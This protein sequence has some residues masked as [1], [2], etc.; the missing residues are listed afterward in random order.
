MKGPRNPFYIR[1]AEQI[2]SDR[3][4]LR[5]FSPGILDILPDTLWDRI[6]VF[7]SAPGGGKTSLLQIFTANALLSLYSYKDFDQYKDIYARMKEVGAI[8]DKGP[9]VLGAMLSCAHTYA[10]LEDLTVNDSQ[11]ERLLLSLLNVRIVL[12]ILRS[13][14]TLK[15]YNYPEDLEKITLECQQE[16]YLPPGVPHKG[17]G[18]IYFNWA[19]QLERNICETIDS[20][21]PP[22]NNHLSGHDSLFALRLF[23][24]DSFLCD[25]SPIA[26]R[27]IVMLDDVQKLTARQR[28]R[29]LA[30]IVDLRAPT[31]VWIAERLEA[32]STDELLSPG[33]TE[34]RDWNLIYLESYWQTY[35]KRFESFARNVADKRTESASEGEID[36]FA[37]CLQEIFDWR[38]FQKDVATAL[39]RIS[40]RVHVLVK[41]KPKYKEWITSRELMEGSLADR[42]IAWRALEILIQRDLLKNQKTF[43]FVEL[44]E[45]NLQAQDQSDVRAAAERFISKEV[46]LPYY[47]G[48]SRLCSMAS[49]NIEQFLNLS[50]ELF[51]EVA[52]ASLLS[53]SKKL[54]EVKSKRQEKIIKQT[55]DRKWDEIVHRVD[56]PKDIRSFIES[57]G[58]FCKWET[59]KP[60]APYSPGVTGI[61]IKMSDRERLRDSKVLD[62]EIFARLARIIGS[63]LSYNILEPILDHKCKGQRWMVLY[64][65]RMFCVHFDLPLQYGGWRE[66]SLK[67]LCHWLEKGFHPP[68][69][70]GDLF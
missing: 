27:V 59:Y 5:L 46:G 30:L 25:G 1:F 17:S 52:S 68:K 62:K 64:L 21:T 34:G 54:P 49:A 20:L 69:D 38:D 29:L 63:C 41:S 60:N 24:P 9:R 10:S 56:R 7:R 4:F 53:L 51:E 35:R 48:F 8:N 16:I 37:G 66:K 44:T 33:N 32:L 15:R 65:N 3:D 55:V 12:S 18:L 57:I 14:L 26:E 13:A 43:S 22:P 23:N 39:E 40:G 28:K 61:A 31:N 11:K 19:S 45:E 67:E 50:G 2:G 70:K 58:E 42:L 6:N 47:Y 36:S